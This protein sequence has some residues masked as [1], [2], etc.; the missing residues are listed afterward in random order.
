MPTWPRSGGRLGAS[1]LN[2]SRVS[3]RSTT[4]ATVRFGRLR[5]KGSG[6]FSPLSEGLRV[7]RHA[8]RGESRRTG[9]RKSKSRRRASVRRHGRGSNRGRQNTGGSPHCG[10][11]TVPLVAGTYFGVCSVR[12]ATAEPSDSRPSGRLSEM[13]D[14]R[15][16][17]SARHRPSCHQFAGVRV[18]TRQRHTASVV[19]RVAARLRSRGDAGRTW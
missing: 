10:K 2:R 14:E 8:T 1:V 18:R 5:S 15:R 9:K 13:A 19:G 12:S 3:R 6:F 4:A 16:L 11:R 17:R 7:G